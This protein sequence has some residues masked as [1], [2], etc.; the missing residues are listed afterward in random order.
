MGTSL[1]IKQVTG[2]SPREPT[3]R[4]LVGSVGPTLMKKLGVLGTYAGAS[5]SNMLVYRIHPNHVLGAGTENLV[6]DVGMHKIGKTKWPLAVK[7]SRAGFDRS[8][9]THLVSDETRRARSKELAMHVLRREGLPAVPAYSFTYGPE[10]FTALLTLNLAAGGSKLEP[11]HNFD[12][13]RLKNGGKLKRDYEL[14]F[15]KLKELFDRGVILPTHH[16][17][18]RAKT[19][20][21]L[22]R[23]L[24]VMRDGKDGHIVVADQDVIVPIY[25]LDPNSKMGKAAL[26]TYGRIQ[27]R[28]A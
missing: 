17:H 21:S 27:K 11:A 14:N 9:G 19:V 20:K 7:V 25:L 6:I 28:S 4:R 13:S 5:G 2:F 26:K 18:Q 3:I 1:T 22:K 16:Q 24:F 12:Y 23:L 8:S 15:K 10:K